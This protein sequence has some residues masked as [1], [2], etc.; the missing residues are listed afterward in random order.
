MVEGVVMSLVRKIII[1][2][3]VYLLFLIMLFPANV[4]VSLAPLPKNI[5]ISGVSG[6][7]WSGSAALV[8]V[9]KRQ[10]EQVR[11]E[12][13][14]WG[15]FLGKANLDLTIGSRANAVNGKGF[16]SL[17]SSA[18]NI[19]QLRFDAPS[20]FLL[21]KT[22]LPFK[23]E[24]EGN[25]S[26]IVQQFAQGQPWCEQLNGKLF[27]QQFQVNNQF[28]KY[29]LG[30]VEVGLTCEDGNIK[31]ATDEAM[32][33]LGLSGTALLKADKL[34]QVSAKIKETTAQPE[35]LKKA[36]SFLGKQ[37]SQGYYPITY[38]GRLPI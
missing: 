21:G 3:A 4:A 29:P 16:I 25:F 26:L 18:I 38:Q 34:V 5:N 15:L 6:T 31:V 8:T 28:G 2:V 33:G 10:L 12:L 32:N 24:V 27:V 7:V 22:R 35:D 37:D 20:E 30:N 19:E 9:D 36:L 1:G 11:W 17:S 13:S 14:P 23:T